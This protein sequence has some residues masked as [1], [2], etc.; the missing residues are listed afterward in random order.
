[1]ILGFDADD[2]LW[3][4]EDEFQASHRTFEALMADFADHDHVNETLLGI[5]R[6]N[7]DRYGFGVK[8][9]T[10]SMIECAVELSNGSATGSVIGEIV[11]LGQTL[12]DRP[13]ELI[14]GVEE[15][16]EELGA[17]TKILITKGDLYH[18]TSRI[19]ASGLQPHFWKTR[20][21]AHKNPQT[22]AEVLAQ[23]DINPAE[24]IMIGNSLPSDVLPVLEIGGR[25]VHVP[26][27]VTWAVELH[28]GEHD[29][30]ELESLRDLPDL[31]REW[32]VH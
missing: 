27:H 18:Q 12:L 3:H 5:E 21:V 13:T 23:H 4:N 24:F 20:V 19:E 28:D 32:G 17:H 9:F 8:A 31:L 25:A 14:D 22:Y 10:L 11:E 7:L 6:R 2:T 29:A 16:L 1:M 15:V 30:P 26:Y